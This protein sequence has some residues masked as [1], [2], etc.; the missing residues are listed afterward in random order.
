MSFWGERMPYM[1]SDKRCRGRRTHRPTGV[2]ALVALIIAV[3]ATLVGP[4]G[5]AA[6]AVAPKDETRAGAP[7]SEAAPE[8]AKP[9]PAPKAAPAKPEEKR[10]EPAAERAAAGR[11]VSRIS[12]ADTCS[13]AIAPDTV[14]TCAARPAGGA[15]FTL[16]LTAATDLVFI[17]AVSTSGGIEYPNLKAPDGSAVT[18][19]PL[20]SYG[21][22]RCP[23]SK[24]GTYTLE[25]TSGWADSG[26]SVSYKALLSGT[27]C[28]T[29]TG[30]E[31]TLGAPKA[32]AAT[33][34]AGSAGD[35]FRLPLAAGAV[36]RAHLT[37][38][39]VYGTVYDA[40][41]K[42]TCSTRGNS[43]DF[44]CKL[45]G[46][47]PFTLLVNQDYGRSVA[48]GF[49]V[50]RLSYPG[51]CPV[52]TV[53]AYGTVP[54]A[55]SATRCRILRVPSAGPFAFGPTEASSWISG[56]LYQ[57]GGAEA[58]PPAPD[59][60]CTLAAG[61]YTWAR[62]SNNTTVDPYG[63]W[64]HATNQ[65]TG[66]TDARDDG[67]ASGP[68][69]GTF[70]G[71]SQRLCRTLPTATGKGLY[72]L[73]NPPA[74]GG[75][76]PVT[77]VYDAK[78]VQQCRATSDVSVCKLTGTAPFRAVLSGPASGAYRMT[79]HGTGDVSGCTTWNRTGFGPSTGMKVDLTADK[80]VACLAV[81]ADKHSTAEMIDYSNATNRVNASVQ[82]YDG[83]G[84]K[85]C[86][87]TGSTTTACVF[88]T[89]PAYPALLI[90]TGGTD[91]YRLVRRDISPTAKCPAPKSL[92]VG[93]ASTGYTF[94]S[95]L[96]ST[97]LQFKTAATDK[98]VIN[99]RTPQAA[100]RT[101]AQLGVAD[102]TGK[103]VCW[104]SAG[105]CRV[106]GSA[107]YFLFGLAAGYDGTTPIVAHIDT[108]RVATAAGWAPECTAN[109]V[110]A[111]S[112]PVRGGTLT[113]AAAGY[114]AVA[115]MKPS[116]RFKVYGADNSA[117]SVSNPWVSMLSST[118][119]GGPRLDPMVNCMNLNAGDFKFQCAT[120]SSAVEGE[121]LLLLDAY[122][123]T[124]PLSY[125]MQ[126]VCD[127]GCANWPPKRPDADSVTPATSA[128]ESTTQVVLH[129]TNLTLGTEVKLAS[130]GNPAS[131]YRMSE[132]VSVSADGTSLT[133]RLSTFGVAPGTYDV[134]LDGTWYTAG[135]RSPGYLPGAYTV[136]AA[137]PAAKI[138]ANGHPVAN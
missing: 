4:V 81:A 29:V 127:D 126:G 1:F 40:T 13:G 80:Q 61:D 52:V 55:S 69:R 84:D 49:T 24:P 88:Q 103:V 46:T 101:G 105:A 85:V 54:A 67:F 131:P 125:S 27:S 138:Q 45:T 32:F 17:Q 117:S 123:A 70:T 56:K 2:T 22:T 3:L 71:A 7:A 108:W 5:A 97:C 137:P 113:E 91:S 114:C 136:T 9:A 64:F 59:V 118:G 98:L 20:G 128:A 96:D 122:T 36:L 116:Q 133:V 30:A 66:C 18:C 107:G 23:T 60:P 82:I 25:L 72:F 90:G 129:G 37:S 21:E 44:D 130:D 119:F 33:V 93:G 31:A 15:K 102:A 86:S 26:F 53:Q 89:G 68:A 28:T 58:C 100:Y 51:G 75:A 11:D 12:A 135:T 34:A 8:A 132:P 111:D 39:E 106:T 6:A 76:D 115:T 73:D 63:I 10:P 79:I 120:T 65:A 50:A 57:M 92:T 48:Y 121:Y 35:C 41:G 124:T 62:D 134:V 95:A 78:G 99:V 87:T 83:A 38:Y 104:T 112:F 19:A 109:R 16:A 74:D 14:H 47:A 94:N 110:S 42:Q 43:P 77:T